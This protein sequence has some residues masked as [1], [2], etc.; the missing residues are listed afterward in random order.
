MS[1]PI[2]ST[3]GRPARSGDRYNE[4][5]RQL[6]F[7]PDYRN[8]RPADRYNLVVIGAGPAGLVAA[9]G[10]ARLGAKV[11]LI[12]RQAMGGDCLNAGCVPSKTLLA[13][14]AE[15][16]PFQDAMS[17]VRAVRAE[18]AHHDS[19]ARYVQEGVDVFLGSARFINPH[20]IRVGDQILRARKILIATGAHPFVPPIP[21]LEEL[22]PLTNETIFELSAPPRRLLV[23]GGGPVG[24]E[25]AQAFVRLGTRVD[26]IEQEPRVLPNDEPE[27]AE[28]VARSLKRDG[29]ELHL[30][31]RARS[32]SQVDG[33]KV[34]ELDGNQ[35]IECDQILVA[36]GRRRSVD[37][38]NLEAAGVRYDPKTGIE[39]NAR[40]QTSQTHIYAAGDV[41]S[42]YPFTHS[43]DAQ[44]RI[45]IRNALFLGRAR[46]DRL[47]IP[48]CT[49]T[50]PELAHVGATRVELDR[51]GRLYDQY[52]VKFGDL[53]R[54]ATDD[55]ADGYAEVLTEK[56]SDHILG[57]TIVGKDAGEQISALVLMMTRRL[58]LGQLGS[59]VLPYPTRSEY[60]RRLADE[61]LRTRLTPGTA[62]ILKWWLARTR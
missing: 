61:Y 8:P 39:V 12:E 56:R 6:V 10:A 52:R 20:R 28:L 38:L 54:G 21:G 3:E 41:C 4:E 2:I 1:S 48:R 13:S 30:A 14:S 46:A 51:A 16:L 49:Y 22:K 40:L 62:R 27:A 57:A 37:D 31:V 42:H 25:L 47:I 23:L 5:W 55:A 43:A 58:G 60:L 44:A 26:L 53:D 19:V 7:P 24:C 59:L 33:S 34:L 45:V 11:A 50:K 18:I 15:R 29:V 9:M 32:A 17:R 36:A 35:R